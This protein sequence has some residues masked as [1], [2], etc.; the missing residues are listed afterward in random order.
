[1]TVPA[2]A[3]QANL[4]AFSVADP[5]VWM[6]D[7]NNPA[8]KLQST[9]IESIYA[10]L[11]S[12]TMVLLVLLCG[13]LSRHPEVFKLG[14]SC[15]K[16]DSMDIVADVDCQHTSSSAPRATNAVLCI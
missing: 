3:A 10:F 5:S 7:F 11:F 2:P 13:A 8:K 12:K 6:V 16:F 14:N 9:V 4:S 15:S 1:M